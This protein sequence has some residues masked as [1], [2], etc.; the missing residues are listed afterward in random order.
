MIVAAILQES[1]HEAVTSH[2]HSVSFSSCAIISLTKS[3]VFLVV[4]KGQ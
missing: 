2:C 4:M 3:S 1:L